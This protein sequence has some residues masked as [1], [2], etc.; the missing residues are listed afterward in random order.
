MMRKMLW[1]ATW[2]VWRP[3]L[4]IFCHFRI[5]GR[6]HCG[7]ISGQF[8]IMANHTHYLDPY[9]LSAAMPLGNN[10]FPIH[11]LTDAFYV[12]M[13]VLGRIVKAYSA[14]PME[15]GLGME[16]NLE[17]S[18]RIL[19]RGG[20][21]GIFPEGHLEKKEGVFLPV[22]PGIALLGIRSGVQ[23][24]PVA[25]SGH[26]GLTVSKFFLRRARIT[27]AFGKPFIMREIA[28][29]LSVAAAKEDLAKSAE[30]AMRRVEEL[31]RD[32]IK[33]E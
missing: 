19:R 24:L 33:L 1:Q 8:I 16:K 30:L 2:L 10:I 26:I 11:F 31:Y 15:R 12:K 23:I 4:E 9:T 5:D 27:V 6:E 29:T 13:P 14:I 18:E 25:I 32:G 3:L 20:V 17:E 28:P 22:K 7:N 21:V